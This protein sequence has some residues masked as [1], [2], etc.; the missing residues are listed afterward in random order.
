MLTIPTFK[1]G[2]GVMVHFKK[3]EDGCPSCGINPMSHTDPRNETGVVV[4]SGFGSF[5]CDTCNHIWT[6]PEGY[7]VVSLNSE[8]GSTYCVPYTL[9][10]PLEDEDAD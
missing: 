4:S 5:R 8:K 6:V 10:E 1:P 3:T 7:W 9:L 2:Q